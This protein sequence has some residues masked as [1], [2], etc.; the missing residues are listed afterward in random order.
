MA[1]RTRHNLSG[2]GVRLI[3]LLTGLFLFIPALVFALPIQNSAT[4]S[5]NGI[6]LD[7]SNATV[8]LNSVG[9]NGPA[10][11]SVLAE[12]NPGSVLTGS[13][14]GFTVAVQPVI[15]VGNSGVDQITLTIPASYTNL[16]TD[17]VSIGGSGIPAGSC[18]SPAAGT[19]CSQLAGNNLIVTFG[20]K[21]TTNNSIISISFTADTPASAGSSTFSVTVDD[22]APVA[23]PQS[24]LPGDADINSTN[25]NTLTVTATDGLNPFSSTLT[26]NPIIVVADGVA[27]STLTAT[28]FDTVAQPLAG[29]N[30]IYTSDRGGLDTITQPGVTNAAGVAIGSITSLSPGITTISATV[31]GIPLNQK[32]T[33]YFTQGLVMDVRKSANKDQVQIGDVI[34]YR[35]ELRNDTANDVVMVQLTDE[36]PPNFVYRAGSA[37]LNGA[38]IADPTGVRRLSFPI[39]TVVAPIDSNSNGVA[40]PGEPGYHEIS[41]Q[42][43]VSAGA[44]PGNYVNTAY[45]SDVCVDCAIS[46]RSEYPVEVTFDP[47]FDLGTIIGKVFEDKNSNGR[48][49]ADEP[50]IAGAMVVLD[51]GSYIKTDPYGRYHFPAVAPGQRLLKINLAGL[52][53][54]AKATGWEAQIVSV[55]PGLLAKANF[56]VITRLENSSI[57]RE[58]EHGLQLD[59]DGGVRPID[60][61]GNV[62]GQYLLI[63]G[64]SIQLPGSEIRLQLNTLD[65]VVNIKGGRLEKPISFNTFNQGD[66]PPKSWR[67]NIFAADGTAAHSLHGDG[68]PQQPLNWDGRLDSGEL[69]TGGSIYQYQIENRYADGTITRSP[70]RMFG[71]DHTSAIAMNL[72]GSAFITGSDRLSKTAREALSEAAAILRQHPHEKIIIEGHTDSTGSAAYNLNLSRRRAQAALQYLTEVEG[73]PADR[74]VTRGRGEDQPLTSNRFEEGRL[75]NRRVE[76]KGEYEKV[77]RARLLDQYRTSPQVAINGAAIEPDE[78]GRFRTRVDDKLAQL[79]IKFS[80]EQGKMLH[81][82]V[83]VPTCNITEPIGLQVFAYGQNSPDRPITASADGV[84]LDEQQTIIQIRL[85]AQTEP[86]NSVLLDGQQIPVD[87]DGHFTAPLNLR[88]GINIASLIISNPDGITRL[89]DLSLKVKSR[90]D[91]GGYIVFAEPTPYLSVQMPPTDRPLSSELFVISGVTAPTNRVSINGLP[92]TLDAEGK[93]SHTLTLPQGKS[94]LNIIVVDPDGHTGQIDRQVDVNDS[95]F[96]LLAFADSKISQLTTSGNLANAGVDS[97]KEI[98]GEG[99]IALYMKGRIAGRY[100]LTAAFDTGTGEFSDLFKDLD[101]AE[102]DRLLTNLDPDKLYPVY[103]DSSSLVYDT[104]SQGKLYL[105]LE[106]DELKLLIGNYS[107]DLHGS[108]LAHYRRTL[109]GGHLVY[110]SEAKTEYNRPTT[111]IE[112]FAAETREIHVRDEVDATGG[113]LYYLSQSDVIE[114]SEQVTI[115]VRDQLTGL[116][117]SRVPQQRNVDYSI[118]Y[119]EGRILFRRPVSSVQDTDRLIDAGLLSGNPVSIQI[120]YEA[121]ADSFEKT[122]YG[123]RVRQQFGDHFAV[124]VTSV[125]DETGAGP[126]NLLGVDAEVRIGKGTRLLTEYATSSGS[127]ATVNI[128]RDGGLNYTAVAVSGIEEGNAWKATAEFDIGEWFNRPDLLKTTLYH[129]QLDSGFRSAGHTDEEG[130]QKSGAQLL[131]RPDSIN[132]LLARFNQEKRDSTAP[133]DPAILRSTMLQ[134][135][136]NKDKWRLLTEYQARSSETVTGSSLTDDQLVAL[137][138]EGELGKRLTG[139]AEQ[140]IA[141]SGESDS[142]TTLGLDYRP[143]NSFSLFT[144]ATTGT[145]GKSA[146]GG[147]SLLLDKSRI[148]LSQRL[149]ENKTSRQ[150]TTVFGGESSDGPYGSRL[151]T[152]YQ[153][154]RSSAGTGS[155]SLFGAEK[156]WRF[157]S[158]LQLMLGGEMGKAKRSTGQSSQYSVASGLTYRYKDSL[159]LSLRAELRE[160]E[161]ATTLKQFLTVNRAEG[162][163]TP[164]LTLIGLYRYSISDNQT[165]GLSE[166]GFTEASI[167]LAIRP[168]DNDF[169][170][171]LARATHLTDRRPTGTGNTEYLD[172]VLDTVAIEW[173]LQLTHELEWVEKNALRWKEETGAIDTFSSR[174]WLSLHR[175]NYLINKSIDAG[176]EYRRLTETAASGQRQGWLSEIGW[177]PKK[178]IRLGVGYNFTDFSDDE[179]SLNNYSVQGWFLRIQGIY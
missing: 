125:Q 50:G 44:V 177:R 148:Y 159:K 150:N 96:F 129:K 78:F 138:I 25:S 84:A 13:S 35:V 10:V 20:T 161:G 146:E 122:A 94:L 178:Q 105:A 97:K 143:N 155:L 113:A 28:L 107:L 54:G 1:A 158:G 64:Q 164:D 2:F 141:I 168:I 33:L 38:S 156:K 169:F 24:A 52:G 65:E 18:P 126:Y 101:D 160:Q 31:G 140:Q 121:T 48:Q 132:T 66:V 179:R 112:L 123:G 152:E 90:E 175:F 128:S 55:T 21:I 100:M 16:A 74:F 23:A 109:F 62:S 91:L 154:N 135:Q 41:Y 93:F 104:E 68:V 40:D 9:S 7:T 4:G 8:N 81:K 59:V 144:N 69:V 34:D 162:T 29:E 39:G 88:E 19:Q 3:S 86:G 157:D 99:R 67:L 120:D 172:T 71:V 118:K 77:E 151:Y 11:D 80:D 92:V 46:N 36:L 79:D 102:T 57:G 124:G 89:A 176:L 30:I 136:Y 153:L 17:T 5:F 70:R 134:W 51:S 167:G 37:R 131:W 117:L 127:E 60:I 142:R 43:I 145:L 170:N 95:P 83:M 42:L 139:S 149:T 47:L 12:I 85:R 87:A 14:T 6:L 137:R 26:A 27:T 73:L 173:S 63:N 82:R 108:E 147:A 56:G 166:A 15:V 114:G 76:I 165:T 171:A 103:G 53:N 32:A 75:L 58:V 98:I 116:L 133:I 110:R 106:S 61:L 119:P 22:T 49:D 72:T 174:S 111:E 115:L 130:T 45:A 163:I